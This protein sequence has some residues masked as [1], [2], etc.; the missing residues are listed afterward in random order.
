[1]TNALRRRWIGSGQN[2][3]AERRRAPRRPPVV[4]ADGLRIEAL[5]P[6]IASLHRAEW[7]RLAASA[8]ESN[9]FL[10]ADFALSAAQHVAT[11]RKPLFLVIRAQHFGA[12][13]MVGLCALDRVAAGRRISLWSHPYAPMGTPLLAASCAPQ[14][15]GALLAWLKRSPV[16][17]DA[18]LFPAIAATGPTAQLLR[19]MNAAGRPLAALDERPRAVL[20]R[21]KTPDPS[22]H[23]AER[24]RLRRKLQTQGDVTFRLSGRDEPAWNDVERFLALEASGWKGEAGSALVSRPGD[25]AFARVALRRMAERGLCRIARLDLDGQPIAMGVVLQSGRNA[26][27]WKIAHDPDFARY[28][29]GVQLTADLTEALA[30]DPSVDLTDSCAVADHPMIDRLWTDRMEIVDMMIGLDGATPG[31]FDRAERRERLAR[32]LRA[33]L[34]QVW[35]RVSGRKAA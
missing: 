13:R 35:L 27:F 22:P 2:V 6:E 33:R 16:R 25:A 10:D 3:Q 28:S 12:M 15:L 5:E 18:L 8:L 11:A 31:G 21:G 23:A 4:T 19:G 1:M 30:A 9:V 17:A 32:A 14:A 26:A 24:R 34:K 7:D 20:L 29:P